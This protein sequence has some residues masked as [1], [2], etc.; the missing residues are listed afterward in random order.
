MDNSSESDKSR[1][2]YSLVWVILVLLVLALA[3]GLIAM[4]N[5]GTSASKTFQGVANTIHAY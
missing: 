3:V 5:S 1:K 4:T 2:S